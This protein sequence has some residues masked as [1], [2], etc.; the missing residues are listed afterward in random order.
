MNDLKAKLN[1]LGENKNFSYTM[2]KVRGV[3]MAVALSPATAMIAKAAT[4]TE[5]NTT[6]AV[7]TIL[8]TLITVMAF[9]GVAFMVMGAVKWISA[10]REQNPEGQATAAKDLGVGAVMLVFKVVLWSSIENALNKALASS[11]AGN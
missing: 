8:G 5:S 4:N 2:A 3:C 1:S 9:I 10:Y 7:L 6:N 11:I